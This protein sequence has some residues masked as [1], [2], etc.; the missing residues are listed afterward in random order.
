[1]CRQAAD[2]SAA[3]QSADGDAAA[4][5]RGYQLPLWEPVWL[6]QGRDGRLLHLWRDAAVPSGEVRLHLHRVI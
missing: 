5:V 1:V 2:H 6:A 4:G 3:D